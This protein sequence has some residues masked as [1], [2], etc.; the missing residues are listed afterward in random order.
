MQGISAAGFLLLALTGSFASI[1]WL[2]SLDPHWQSSLYGLWYF[3]G[4]GL[5]GLTFTVVVANWLRQREPMR[6]ALRPQHFHDYGKLFFAFTMLWA[7]LSFSQFLLIWAGNLP[8]EI[9]FYLRRAHGGWGIV[10]AILLLGHFVLPFLILLSADVKRRGA[11]LVKVAIWM[12][13]MRWLDYF[14]NVAPTLQALHGNGHGSMWLK[15]WIDLAAIVGLGGI[16]VW[17]YLR[18]LADRPLLPVNDPYLAE[19]LAQ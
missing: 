13:A 9:P 4:L 17:F 7:Y 15:L 10:S 2:M 14:W 19:V 8:E 16:W 12:L 5:S 6:G 11:V 1:D 18:A 3:A